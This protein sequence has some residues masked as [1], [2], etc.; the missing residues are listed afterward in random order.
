MVSELEESGMYVPPLF[1]FKY[2]VPFEDTIDMRAP[3]YGVER[4]DNRIITGVLPP[5]AAELYSLNVPSIPDRDFLIRYP[6]GMWSGKSIASDADFRHIPGWGSNI[7]F[8]TGQN[9]R[10]MA[11]FGQ[12]FQRLSAHIPSIVEAER[13][14]EG[15]V[16]YQPYTSMGRR[17]QGRE[18][19][20]LVDLPERYSELLNRGITRDSLRNMEGR[21]NAMMLREA[22]AKKQQES[23][24]GFSNRR[25]IVVGSN[26]NA[27]QTSITP[28]HP[29]FTKG[30]VKRKQINKQEYLNLGPK[31]EEKIKAAVATG[32]YTQPGSHYIS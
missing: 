28:G 8:E 20:R 16:V 18:K 12:E 5:P 32:S 4:D 10:A 31:D 9:E 23:I 17:D 21:V 29:L 25:S 19:R 24:E 3:F 6:Q 7:A 15:E 27:W 26:R 13:Q 22:R 14:L 1:P 2:G 11:Q 30:L